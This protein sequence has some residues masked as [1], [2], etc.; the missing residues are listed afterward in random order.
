MVKSLVE[1][2]G[3]FRG[4]PL[5]DTPSIAL[6]QVVNDI[7][8][9]HRRADVRLNM[10]IWNH[11]DLDYKSCAVCAAGAVML[12]RVGLGVEPHQLDDTNGVSG[13]RMAALDGL[14]KGY[15]GTFLLAW[16]T[17]IPRRQL[18]RLSSKWNHEWQYC[19][20]LSDKEV[21]QMCRNFLLLAADLE[22]A[23]F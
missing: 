20:K 7:R 14:R 18:V 1:V 10:G 9:A 22:K 13:T 21:K 6:R 16:G 11:A 12:R 23:G 19:G 15:V 5:S 3:K 4:P 2:A 17:R 8:W